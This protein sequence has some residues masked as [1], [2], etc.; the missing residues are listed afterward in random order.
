MRLGKV[1]L[2][3]AIRTLSFGNRNIH[4]EYS[5]QFPC[6]SISVKV[7][8]RCTHFRSP[9]APKRSVLIFWRLWPAVISSSVVLSTNDVGPQT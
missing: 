5:A 7:V 3:A 8:H 1:P 9:V 2:C 6:R 4:C